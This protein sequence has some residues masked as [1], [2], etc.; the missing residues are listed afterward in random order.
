MK[1]ANVV[2]SAAITQITHDANM[3]Q[4]N[5][6]KLEAAKIDISGK[7]QQYNIAVRN[8]E[9]VK[10]LKI[11]MNTANS[12]K[13][14]IDDMVSRINAAEKLLVRKRKVVDIMTTTERNLQTATE[15]M[16]TVLP[17]IYF[18]HFLTR[19]TTY[20]NYLLDTI[21]EMEM[22]MTADDNGIHIRVDNKNFHQLSSGEK[23]RVRT[24]TTLAFSL[25]SRQSD[26]LFIDEV[27]DA[28]IDEEGVGDL[29]NML[30]TV[31]RE[32]Y[33][34]VIVVSHQPYLTTALKPDHILFIEKDDNGA[35]DIV[36]TV[37]P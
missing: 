33:A 15:A 18:D 8:M 16:N 19:L 10:S 29:A 30:S 9:E 17:S 36:K 11:D 14:N 37:R 5:V 6:N 32:F 28:Y 35:S 25:L 2:D 26:T 21:S 24:E 34:K 13:A 31:I 27:F 1:E 20:C 4:S 22:E 23:Q 3:A 12:I 7:I